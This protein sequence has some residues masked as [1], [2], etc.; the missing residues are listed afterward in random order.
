MVGPAIEEQTA[1][2]LDNLE[3]I[4][5]EAGSGLDRLV[6]TTV[7]LQN[8]DDF[9]GMNSVYAER[10]GDDSSCALDRRGRSAPIRRARG[11]RGDRAPLSLALPGQALTP[12][13]VPTRVG[14]APPATR[15]DRIGERRACL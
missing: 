3:A 11:N 10:V 13:R 4:L 15:C 9:Q 14:R 12:A 7:F 8:L 2:T 6:K 1:Q 5:T